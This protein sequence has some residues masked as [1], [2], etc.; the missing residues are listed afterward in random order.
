MSGAP[1]SATRV[2]SK[3]APLECSPDT[4]EPNT[5]GGGGRGD[6]TLRVWHTLAAHFAAGA[7]SCLYRLGEPMSDTSG[8][9]R[10]TLHLQ[11][12]A[13]GHVAGVVL[14][15]RKQ[16]LP[17]RPIFCAR[18]QFQYHVFDAG[19]ERGEVG[20]GQGDAA[21]GAAPPLPQQLALYGQLVTIRWGGDARIAGGRVPVRRRV[22][23]LARGFRVGVLRCCCGLQKHAQPAEQSA[24][25]WPVG[26]RGGAA[27]ASAAG[28]AA[29]TVGRAT[30]ADEPLLAPGL[31]GVGP[32]PAYSGCT[33]RHR[34]PLPRHPRAGPSPPGQKAASGRVDT[35]G[36][37]A[38]CR[39]A[40]G[41]DL[42]AARQQRVGGVA[43]A[44]PRAGVPVASP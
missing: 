28:R 27:A 16:P 15:P 1:S 4:H 42:F 35:P 13:A 34:L 5:F 2:R 7:R 18:R 6:W 11:P 19:G 31:A 10:A 39:G 17:H 14:Q 21:G 3:S 26:D 25:P 33:L 40:M 12:R 29:Q 24:P 36:G 37:S 43:P 38:A 22:G 23:G 9:A 8:S 20:G 44:G 30:P 32:P 41:K